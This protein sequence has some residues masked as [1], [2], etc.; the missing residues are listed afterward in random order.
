MMIND[1]VQFR[2]A[3]S[4][5]YQRRQA[6]PKEAIAMPNCSGDVKLTTGTE[7]LINGR[8]RRPTEGYSC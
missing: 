1:K 6:S 3:P 5:K 2:E 4:C 8:Q 7:R